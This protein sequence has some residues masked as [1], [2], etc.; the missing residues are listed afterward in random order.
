MP[1]EINKKILFKDLPYQIIFI[2][3]DIIELKDTEKPRYKYYQNI[4]KELLFLTEFKSEINF[5]WENKIDEALN[6]NKNSDI[7]Y[8]YYKN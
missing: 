8:I 3:K 4:L 1:S 2:Y 7:F 5:C 6:D